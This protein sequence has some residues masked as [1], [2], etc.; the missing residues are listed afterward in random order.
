[1]ILREEGLRGAC[2]RYAGVT[3]NEWAPM[4]SSFS[5]FSLVRNHDA[6]RLEDVAS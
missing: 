3:G 2:M 6:E 5:P 4:N 1:M